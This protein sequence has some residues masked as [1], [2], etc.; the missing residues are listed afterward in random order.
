MREDLAHD[1]GKRFTGKLRDGDPAHAFGCRR[2]G[3]DRGRIDKQLQRKMREHMRDATGKASPFRLGA[4]GTGSVSESHAFLEIARPFGR[5]HLNHAA[6][7]SV[8]RA[9][10][11]KD[12]IVG[13]LEDESGA[14]PQMPLLLARFA[15]KRFR[16]APLARQASLRP[17]T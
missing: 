16:I 2:G 8:R 11:Q 14:T 4:S 13:T 12:R 17:G 1:G 15:R 5:R 7:Q 3:A 9:P 6:E 10:A